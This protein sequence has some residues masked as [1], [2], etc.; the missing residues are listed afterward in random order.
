L[1][2]VHDRDPLPPG[3]PDERPWEVACII[4]CNHIMD[5]AEAG[6]R[7]AVTALVADASRHIA[8]STAYDTLHGVLWAQGAFSIKPFYPENFFVECN[9]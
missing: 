1:L 2:S 3:H 8:I 9:S 6:L 7:Y 5:N 4:Q